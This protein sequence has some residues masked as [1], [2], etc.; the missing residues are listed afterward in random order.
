MNSKFLFWLLITVWLITALP[1]EAQQPAKFARIG[2]LS[3]SSASLEPTPSR[4]KSFRQ[5]LADFG[6]I[7]GQNVAIEYRY[8]EGKVDRLP[9]LAA[10][11]VRLKVDVIITTGR[12]STWAAKNATQTIPIVIA[13]GT[14][15]VGSG[16]VASLAQ[17]GGNITGLSSSVGLQV[18]GKRIELLKEAVPSVQSV[19]ALWHQSIPGL[20]A[21]RKE[22]EDAARALRIKVQLQEV[23]DSND[24]ERALSSSGGGQ[25]R[26]L[27][28]LTGA[29]TRNNLRRIAELA[30]KYRLPAIGGDTQFV[31]AGGL[32]S[33]G[34]GSI[35]GFRRVAYFVDKILKGT[36]PA[37]LPVEQPTK[38]ELVINLKTAKQ[39]GLTIPPNILARADK[40]IR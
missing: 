36:K 25:T 6:Y 32:M 40:V 4:L 34:A 5:G 9:D 13:A 24:L 16:L 14:D 17:P 28:T 15:P 22:M 23:K 21:T 1:A 3:P 12:E 29:F 18:L 30:M 35:D 37:D 19:F 11:L 2:W 33:Y 7:E 8:A 31:E 20:E 27:I 39:I 26:G 10:E 38:F